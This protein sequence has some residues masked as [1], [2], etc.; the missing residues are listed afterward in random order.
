[1]TNGYKKIHHDCGFNSQISS[2]NFGNRKLPSPSRLCPSS[3]CAGTPLTQGSAHTPLY[4]LPAPGFPPSAMCLLQLRC[5]CPTVGHSRELQGKC[6]SG[7]S[8]SIFAKEQTAHLQ[9]KSEH[10]N[11]CYARMHFCLDGFSKFPFCLYFGGSFF[12]LST[13]DYYILWI[14][15]FSLQSW[16][17]T[18]TSSGRVVGFFELDVYVGFKVSSLLSWRH[19]GWD[20]FFLCAAGWQS[21]WLGVLG[22]AGVQLIRK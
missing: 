21:Y 8:C 22:A 11:G 3:W 13:L 9:Y 10:Y 7:V 16:T 18:H 2:G 20:S 15:K 17:R 4:P 1:M 5:F 12:T 6:V 19:L 14:Y